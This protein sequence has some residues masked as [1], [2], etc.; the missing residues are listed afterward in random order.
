MSFELILP[1]LRPI[2]PLLLDD[3]IRDSVWTGLTDELPM[4]RIHLLSKMFSSHVNFA[5]VGFPRVSL[6]ESTLCAPNFLLFGAFS[7]DLHTSQYPL[8]SL[9]GNPVGH[10]DK[11]D[12]TPSNDFTENDIHSNNSLAV[13]IRPNQEWIEGFRFQKIKKRSNGQYEKGQEKVVFLQSRLQL[14]Q[15]GIS[16]YTSEEV[17]EQQVDGISISLKFTSLALNTFA[18]GNHFR[19][20]KTKFCLE[21]AATKIAA[22]AVKHMSKFMIGNELELKKQNDLK[23]VVSPLRIKLNFKQICER[24]ETPQCGATL[25]EKLKHPLSDPD[26]ISTFEVKRHCVYFSRLDVIHKYFN[27]TIRPHDLARIDRDSAIDLV[28]DIDECRRQ[29]VNR[30]T[31][32]LEKSPESLLFIFRLTL[33][34]AIERFLRW[35]HV[36]NVNER[37]P[38]EL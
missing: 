32:K 22:M 16:A 33:E 2:E 36:P 35:S 28:T 38:H 7:G 10:F 17:R 24:F 1:F 37:R 4:E 19:N 15:N 31:L 21:A 25:R 6:Q 9:Q 14:L 13:R 27:R 8:K 23:Q 30:G 18:I 26:E 3:C 5:Q 20:G 29:W 12:L 11:I 34:V